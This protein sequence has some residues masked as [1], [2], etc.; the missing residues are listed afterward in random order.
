M[1]NQKRSKNEQQIFLS[2]PTFT[3][4][5]KVKSQQ[6]LTHIRNIKQVNKEIKT[7]KC[8]IK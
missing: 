4:L 1:Q 3:T 6:Q 5:N 2:V 7:T 8:I